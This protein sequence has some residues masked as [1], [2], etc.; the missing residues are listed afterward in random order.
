MSLLLQAF[1]TAADGLSVPVGRAGGGPLEL[2]SAKN[3]M[4]F[5][6]AFLAAAAAADLSASSARKKKGFR[7]DNTS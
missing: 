4:R 3:V 1:L 2:S 6:A 7:Q 5:A